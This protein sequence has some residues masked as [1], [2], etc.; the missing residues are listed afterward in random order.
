MIAEF[1][2]HT[3]PMQV[4]QMDQEIRLDQAM[5]SFAEDLPE[6]FQSSCSY[7]V[8][9][10]NIDYRE[11]LLQTIRRQPLIPTPLFCSPKKNSKKPFVVQG[12]LGRLW[13]KY[14]QI[15]WVIFGNG[16]GLFQRY[17]APNSNCRSRINTLKPFGF[18]WRF[19]EL[20]K[21]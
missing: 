10:G 17:F 2:F 21:A 13:S 11:S 1:Y 3:D 4:I 14:Y 5:E 12:G 7:P 20:K 6:T 19:F 8:E 16:F 9:Y 15:L 18:M